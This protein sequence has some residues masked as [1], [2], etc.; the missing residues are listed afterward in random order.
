MIKVALIG[1]GK[2]GISHLAILGA[3]PEVEV[4]GVVDPSNLITDV[5]NKYSPFPCFSDMPTMLE[6]ANP[7]AVLVAVPTK[8]HA[9][10]VW[11]L[12]EKGK[13][14]FVEKP[15]CLNMDDGA[16]LVA[17][18]AE[19]NV[20]N[21]VG[22]HNKFL[23]TFNEAKEL[24]ENGTI[25]NLL[26]FTGDMNG[27]VVVKDKQTNWRAKPEE[28]GG[29]LMDYAAHLIDLINFIVGPITEVHGALIKSYYSGAVDDGIYALLESD[30]EVSGVINVNWSDE[31]FRKMSTQITLL[32]TEG[33]I[34]VDATELKVYLKQDKPA[35]EY[36]KGW[37]I[38]HINDFSEDV[39]YYLRG[40]EYSAQLD[41][42]IRAIQREVPNDINNFESAFQTDK[43]IDL[44]KNYKIA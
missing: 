25:G 12:L 1:A 17:L 30:D 19:K 40:E 15:F 21:Q 36:S 13:H 9:D 33:K 24:V 42:F 16:Y 34:V 3:H 7:D 11:K 26:H 31:T 44:I 32:G 41:H 43:V 20:V 35:C 37:T 18:A 5:L 2:M 22:Y 39:D 27:P 4:V 10:L 6:K 23:G 38:K 8:Y 14:V 29:C 28:G